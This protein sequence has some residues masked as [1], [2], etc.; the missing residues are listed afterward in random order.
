MR[1]FSSSGPALCALALIALAGC[2][3]SAPPLPPDTTSINRTR[4]MT[5]SDFS[6]TDAAMSCADI[7]AERETNTGAIKAANE[8]IE[9]NR[10]RDQAL[11]YVS[12]LT[13]PFI[14]NDNDPERKEI[15]QRYQ[16]QDTLIKLATVKACP[17]G[18]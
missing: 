1:S 6:A 7:A 12:V 18:S 15:A 9:G 16:R 10:G 11:I 4:T 17:G 13:A 8:R 14:A 5:L 2:V 3:G